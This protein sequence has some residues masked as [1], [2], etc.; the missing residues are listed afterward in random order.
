MTVPTPAD[1]EIAAVL[2]ATPPAPEDDPR[3]RSVVATAVVVGVVG[4][5]YIGLGARG[6]NEDTF[7]G[8]LLMMVAGI[9]QLAAAPGLLRGHRPTRAY[10]VLLVTGCAVGALADDLSALT[11]YLLLGAAGVAVVLLTLV[12]PV[13]RWFET[14]HDPDAVK[15]DA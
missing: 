15:M 4:A 11:H 12:A 3:P 1:P 5:L 9:A 6:R 13:R 2:A 8:G 14:D 7:G 10:A